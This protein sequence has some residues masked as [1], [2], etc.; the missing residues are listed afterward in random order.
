MRTIIN[1]YDQMRAA[2]V[3]GLPAVAIMPDTFPSSSGNSLQ[4]GWVV[5]SPG[6]CLRD[7][8]DKPAWYE[9]KNARPFSERAC[10]R[11][12]ALAQAKAWASER[13]GVTAWKRNHMRDY[14]DARVFKQ[15]PLEK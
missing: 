2:A 4:S 8:A 12:E 9:D 14:V 5:I 6:L 7:P 1:T 11:A 15:F 10:T 3:A 13:F